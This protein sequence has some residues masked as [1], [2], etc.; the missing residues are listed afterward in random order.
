[1]RLAESYFQRLLRETPALEAVSAL[2]RDWEL[3]A[4]E[5]A[6]HFG[7]ALPEYSVTLCLIYS[8]EV[9]NGG[10]DQF[11]SNRGGRYMDDNLA[12]LS[13]VGLTRPRDILTKACGV[14]PDGR[15]PT[16]REAADAVLE[17]LSNRSR[18][19]L[20]E[21]DRELW[22]VPAVDETLLQYLRAHAAELLLPERGLVDGETS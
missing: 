10:H 4:N 7:L 18:K 17:A 9:G 11:F 22:G 20:S 5:D 8:G 1:M 12:S 3:R 16:D 21:L 14:F 15:V 2:S 6:M 13:R 19:L